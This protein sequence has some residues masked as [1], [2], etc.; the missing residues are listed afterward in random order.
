MINHKTGH[1]NTIGLEMNAVVWMGV[2]NALL[3]L[4]LISS[5][6]LTGCTSG[7]G[8]VRAQDNPASVE[9]ATFVS[10]GVSTVTNTPTSKPEAAKNIE[11]GKAGVA[12]DIEYLSS[13]Y[14]VTLA[15]TAFETSSY[16]GDRYL[17]AYFE[18]KNTGDGS[19]YLSP[20]IYALDK[21]GEKY[22]KTFA[23]GLPP[24]YDK[25]LDFIK[26]LSP[27][28]KMSGW[29]AIKVPEETAEFGLFFEYTNPFVDKKPSYI[30]Y[31]IAS[32]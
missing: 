9:V 26:K 30:K 1:L 23:I 22:D 18:I 29:A 8:S 28:T 21:D 20:D 16:G 5:F 15:K 31:R 11:D 14:Q 27:G 3:C 10:N 6:V 4:L 24:D 7:S 13:N 25:T 19:E 17:L 12:Y 32:K 2:K